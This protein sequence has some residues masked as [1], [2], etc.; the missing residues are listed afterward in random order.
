MKRI[1]KR[2]SLVLVAIMMVFSLAACSSKVETIEKEE[3]KVEGP[4][5]GKTVILHTNDIHG[6]FIPNPDDEE[7]TDGGLEGYATV[8]YVKKD[9]ESKGATV[10]LVDDGD[11]SQGS[12]Y[13]SLNKGA[14][15]AELMNEVGYDIVGLGN[16]EFDYGVDQL[17]S[18]FEGKN[19]KVLC[20]NV[21]NGDETLFDSEVV[22]KVGKLK[23]GFFGLLTPETQT[24]VNPNYVK[25]LT[26]TEGQD[27]YEVAQKEADLLKDE[28][29]IVICMSH[30]GVDAESAG[31]TSEDV[32]AN[33]TGIDFIIDGHSHTVMTTGSN[34][35]PIQ[36]TGTKTQNIGVIVID[37]ATKAIEQNY[38]LETNIMAPDTEILDSAE[39]IMSEIDTN[40]GTI[41]ANT[42]V[43]LDGTKEI[44]RSEETN[45]GDLVADAMLYEVLKAGSIDVDDANVVVVTNGGGIRASI[46]TGGISMKDINS[47]NP[48]GNTVA[49]DYV[50]GAEL[51]EILEA[52]TYCTPETIGGFPQ[53][54][55]INF[56]IDTTVEY[57]A[58]EEYPDSTYAKP[59]SIKRVTIQSING[60]DFD[61]NA[62][63][64]VITNNFC[65]AGGDTYYALKAA[66]DAGN[67]FDTG[68]ALDEAVVDYITNALGGKIT[69]DYAEPQGRITIIK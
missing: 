53:V 17:K 45:L 11:Y 61:E 16:H 23:I 20:S 68:I 1:L 44:V 33:T 9:F 31:N 52:S 41:F 10:I 46:A 56:T 7:A 13:V 62:T 66:Y 26:F 67:G 57:D 64:A 12:I 19:Y 58:G 3:N 28:A 49:V 14:A 60:N 63:Y 18:N 54:A 4:Y 2:V 47:V 25:E 30:L 38:L 27:L 34:G 5:T 36:S 6:G 43:D 32:Y 37:N 51:L 55:G 29:D 39:A 48:F 21:F 22:V 35:E 24:K 42:D 40:Y 59:N 69:T 65:A 50:T 8:S 15:A